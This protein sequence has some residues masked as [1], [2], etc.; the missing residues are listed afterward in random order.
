[1]ALVADI[2]KNVTEATPVYAAVGVT[3]LAVEKVRDARSQ[4]V[5]ARK[6]LAPAEITAQAEKAA[7]Q[8]Q[9]AP[10]VLFNRGRVF[11]GKAQEQYDA[12]AAR[13]E[14]LVDRIRNQKSTQDLLHQVD[15]TVSVGKGAV[16]T[17]R[18]AVTETERSARATLTTGRREAAKA[19]DSVVGTIQKDA[20]ATSAQ[21]RESA[22]ATR[23]AA[24]RTATTARKGVD[25]STSRAKATT[26][27]AR[28]ATTR[29]R[30]ATSAAATKVGD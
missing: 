10:A 18:N 17:V 3:D 14:K 30:K 15:Q 29:A 26:T 23:T 16:T 25:A 28:K 11:A 1:M 4:A 5:A 20:K 6:A 12:L 19:T 21:V 22:R 24:K 9:E 27:T 2:K 8:V 13:G 7:K